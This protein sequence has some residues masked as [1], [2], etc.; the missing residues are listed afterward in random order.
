MKKY[1]FLFLFIVCPLIAKAQF[2]SLL[3]EE[4][5]RS[6]VKL[7]DEFM[8]R[9]NGRESRPDIKQG[10]IDSHKTNILLLFDL[11]MFKSKNDL[12]FIEAESFAQRIVRDSIRINYSDT[13]WCAKAKCHG[14]LSG[15]PVDFILYLTVEHREEDMYK[16]VVA[17]A[18]GKIFNLDAPK[19]HTPFMLMP[20][21]HETNFMSLF[22]M[23]EETPSYIKDFMSKH[24]V[25]NQ[26]SVFQALVHSKLLKIEYVSDLEFL[27]FQV[28]NYMF[29]VKH[30]ERESLN[31]G[32]LINSFCKV[33]DYDKELFFNWLYNY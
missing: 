25:L 19:D 28:P 26:T 20:D 1:I 22:R 24:N 27:F 6:R 3:N 18:E 17:Q 32:W 21:D 14:S 13:A 5:Y 23:T 11:A 33:D 8:E 12:R 2:F 4:L 30:I 7:V 9:F 29:S 10:G 31:A 16:W 15:K